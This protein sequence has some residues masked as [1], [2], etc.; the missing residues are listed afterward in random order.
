MVHGKTRKDMQK[1]IDDCIVSAVKIGQDTY[2]KKLDFGEESILI[3][4]E[5]LDGY[6]ERYLHPEEDDG[7]IHDHVN[8][9]AY[10]FGIYVGEVLLRRQESDYSWQETEYGIVLAKEAGNLINPAA[11]AMKHIM[12]GKEGGDNI[13]SFFD[14]ACMIMAGKFK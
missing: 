11:K 10:I 2:G 12:N 14:V 8:T 1:F 6:H 13:K 9:Y 7:L 4:D 3:V 5:I